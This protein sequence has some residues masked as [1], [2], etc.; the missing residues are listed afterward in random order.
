MCSA[1]ALAPKISLVGA[2]PGDPELLTVAAVRAISDPA[3]LVVADRLVSSEILSLVAGELRVAGKRPGCAEVAQE[4]IYDW[5][6]EAVEANRTVV[7]LKIGDPFVFGRG[8]EEVLAFR[9][10]LGV[11]P[12]VVPGVSAA[13][14]A[15]LAA[16]VPVTHRGAA[17]QV[18]ITTG[19][20]RAG[21]SPEMPDYHPHQTVVCLMAVGRIRHVATTLVAKSF[22]PD[23][24][25]LVVE[26]ASC[27]D[28]RVLLGDLSD[29]AD[30]VDL[31]GIK[32]PSTMVFGNAVKV[33]YAD[34][35]HGLVQD[36]PP[37]GP[38][39]I[40]D[41][42]RPPLHDLLLLG[43]DDDRLPTTPC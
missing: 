8:G 39:D 38:F 36:A 15:P 41:A 1:T 27:P 43:K 42:P 34:T 31:N 26:R 25:A 37:S 24:P 32:P 19:H 21:S 4:E 3:A 35:P 10:R 13:L 22:P 7:R 18:V 23:C 12:R 2:G 28:Q 30:L 20:G 29:I 17:H 16:G 40:R 5:V 14:A 11:E 33:L 9:E 6:C